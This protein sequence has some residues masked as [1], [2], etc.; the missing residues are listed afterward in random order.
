MPEI[1]SRSA[2]LID[3]CTGALLYFKNGDD[4]IPPA[5]LAKLMTMRLVMKE[6]TEGRASYDEIIPITVESWAQSQPPRSSLMFL[7]PGQT[8]TLREILLG[9][10]VPSGNDAAVAAALRVAP[11]MEAFVYLMNAEAKAMGLGVTTFADASGYS[12]QNMT[13]AREFAYFCMLY[14]KAHP[15]SLKDFHSVQSFS[16]PLEAN[17]PENRLNNIRTITQEPQNFLLRT[18]PG[19]DGLKTGFIPDSRYNIALTAQREG[20]RFILVLMGSPTRR[21][22][23]AESELLLTWAFENFKTVRPVSP[24]ND[25][26]MTDQELKNLL[27]VRLWKGKEKK[28]QLKPS[29]TVD[30]TS[31]IDRA[32]AL[33]FELITD[34][35]IAP[36]PENAPAGFL[37]ISDEYGELHRSPLVTAK[38]SERGNVFR[39]MWHSV[40]L[41][42]VKNPA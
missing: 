23:L 34:K 42:F 13:T 16:F 37:V 30:F 14:I 2:V 9:L 40:R 31:P 27:S 18:F 19:A 6:I 32:N 1:E 29:I 21:S 15:N 39:R 35:L 24:D 5:S 33:S 20:T 36:L 10:A 11:N 28:I 8:V 12:N 7:E 38:A 17:V 3:A 26:F 41:L 4:E 25:Q 22:R